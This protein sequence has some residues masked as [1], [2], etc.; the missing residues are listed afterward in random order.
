MRA[1]ATS[2]ADSASNASS[3]SVAS[4]ALPRPK[5]TPT[6][7]ARAGAAAPVATVESVELKARAV[8]SGSRGGIG[9]F[10]RVEIHG[11]AWHDGRD[12]VLVDHLRHRIAKQHHILV[13]RL[14]VALQLDPVDEV[15]RNRNMLLAQQVQEGVL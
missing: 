4:K 14:D 13:E 7:I 6:R 3:S 2:P 11:P 5:S 15:D 9:R 1:T 12:R 8:R 10:G